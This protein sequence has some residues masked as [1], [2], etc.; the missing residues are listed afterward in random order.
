MILR[1]LYSNQTLGDSDKKKTLRDTDKKTFG[2]TDKQ[3]L[4]VKD[5]KRLGD[6]DKKKRSATRTNTRSSPAQLKTM[7]RV[8]ITKT[9][10]L[11]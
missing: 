6:T 8:Y 7:V 1:S 11:R 10:K 9:V 4:I 2:D 5:K 3:T